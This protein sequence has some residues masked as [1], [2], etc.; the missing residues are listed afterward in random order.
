MSGDGYNGWTNWPVVTSGQS[1]CAN[2]G[3]PVRPVRNPQTLPARW[4]HYNT[5]PNGVNASFT[6]CDSNGRKV[7]TPKEEKTRMVNYAVGSNT[8]GYLSEGDAFVTDNYE[9]AC[10]VLTN[11]LLRYAELLAEN[12]MEEAAEEATEEARELGY[13]AEGTEW[14]FH[15][16]AHGDIYDLGIIFWL[17]TTNEPTTD[18]ES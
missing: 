2:C 17:V 13:L 8:P 16:P 3:R 10:Q 14:L 18:E 6:C 7:A 5:L 4:V 1:K 11:D 15:L 12:G 9:T